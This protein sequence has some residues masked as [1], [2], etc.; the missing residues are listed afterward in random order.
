MNKY[1][2]IYANGAWAVAH[3][4][5]TDLPSGLTRTVGPWRGTEQRA[6]RDKAALDRIAL[7]Q[8][9]LPQIPTAP[10]FIAGGGYV[11]HNAEAFREYRAE[12][13]HVATM[14]IPKERARL[15]KA[16]EIGDA[17]PAS[18]F[19]ERVI[20]EQGSRQLRDAWHRVLCTNSATFRE[21]GQPYYAL[22]PHEATGGAIRPEVKQ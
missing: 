6:E 4:K 1:Q 14:E 2:V 16:I 10:S 5:C 20:D 12:L 21:Y 11:Q 8:K 17:L 7:S 22:N 13:L 18:S 9:L 19:V 3:T 15:E